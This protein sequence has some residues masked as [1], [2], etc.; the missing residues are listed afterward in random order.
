MRVDGD[1]IYSITDLRPRLT[2]PEALSKTVEKGHEHRGRARSTLASAY[3]LLTLLKDYTGKN[4]HS[5]STE[6]HPA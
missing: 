2:V 1:E 6:L 5:N 4:H 3:V